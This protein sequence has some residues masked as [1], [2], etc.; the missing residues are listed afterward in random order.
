MTTTG[1]ARASRLDVDPVDADAA[2]PDHRSLGAASRSS[3]VRSAS[4]RTMSAGVG[5][6]RASR[7]R[8][9]LRDLL[10][11][12]MDRA[13]RDDHVAGGRSRALREEERVGADADEAEALR[14]E[15]LGVLARA[16]EDAPRPCA[17]RTRRRSRPRAGAPSS[18]RRS[19]IGRADRQ[20]RR[21]RRSPRSPRASSTARRVSIWIT[22]SA[23]PSSAPK[24]QPFPRFIDATPRARPA[25]G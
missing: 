7:R 1:S 4:P 3:A 18:R 15:A 25:G 19:E 24:P 16:R 10:R 20:G 21:R 17:R 13:G 23:S 8:R 5:Q 6:A 14:D 11:D 22:H 12:G 9:S 2:P